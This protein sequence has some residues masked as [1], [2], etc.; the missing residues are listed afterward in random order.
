MPDLENL[1]LEGW[2]RGRREAGALKYSTPV[3]GEAQV[4]ACRGGAA[5]ALSW[6]TRSTREQ[7]LIRAAVADED[8]ASCA[9]L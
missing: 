5:S 2:G 6:W 7:T 9:R 3:P 1:D 4:K 8:Q